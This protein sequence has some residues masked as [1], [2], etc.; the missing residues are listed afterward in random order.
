MITITIARFGQAPQGIKINDGGTVQD[1][2]NTAGVEVKSGEKVS[3]EGVE[4]EMSNE[5]E[6][7][8]VISIYTPKGGGYR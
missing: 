6:N 7:G 8:D 5:V 1:A 3:V 2:L 4:A